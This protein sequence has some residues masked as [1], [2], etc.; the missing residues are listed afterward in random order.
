MLNISQWRDSKEVEM[1]FPVQKKHWNLLHRVKFLKV[2]IL[3]GGIQKLSR[4][5]PELTGFFSRIPASQHN[6]KWTLWVYMSWSTAAGFS[7][8]TRTISE[9]GFGSRVIREWQYFL[10]FRC[11]FSSSVHLLSYHLLP[12]DILPSPELCLFLRTIYR[13]IWGLHSTARQQV[14]N[15][16][17]VSSRCRRAC[18]KGLKEGWTREV[19]E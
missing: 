16:W 19:M 1:Q 11:R 14:P 2:A 8:Q 18:D 15:D 4:V 7:Q 6:F 17:G 12:R 3:Y 13:P 10:H 9:S 5:T